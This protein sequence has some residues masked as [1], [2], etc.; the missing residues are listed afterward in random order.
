MACNVRNSS[1]ESLARSPARNTRLF[2]RFGLRPAPGLR[3]P[4]PTFPLHFPIPTATLED[5]IRCL[6]FVQGD[7]Q[8]LHALF[9]IL[10]ILVGE[11]RVLA[12]LRCFVKEQPPHPG[13]PLSAFAVYALPT[14]Q[15]FRYMVVFF[16]ILTSRLRQPLL[17][18]QASCFR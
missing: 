11:D 10:E 17:H 16:A 7:A 13:T 12:G 3:P 5:V 9:G 1:G 14:R 18:G 6:E 4:R 2:R 8:L 15:H